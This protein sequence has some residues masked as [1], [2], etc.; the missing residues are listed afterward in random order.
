MPR[1]L[2]L[3]D[4]PLISMVVGE[5]LTDLGCETMGP[6]HSVRSAMALLDEGSPDGAILD[7]ALNGEDCS[8]VAER[9]RELGVP[10]ALATGHGAGSVGARFMGASILSKP[11]DFEGVSAVVAKLLGAPGQPE[12]APDPAPTRPV[13][14]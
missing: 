6:A 11:F 4:E 13:A 12:A 2:V 8:A 14:V 9:L 3:D 5:W 7:V 10:F 1:I